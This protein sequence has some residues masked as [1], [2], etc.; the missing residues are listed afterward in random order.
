MPKDAAERREMFCVSA[1]PIF[2]FRVAELAGVS[3]GAVI[4]RKS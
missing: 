4:H 2:D 1:L 3:I